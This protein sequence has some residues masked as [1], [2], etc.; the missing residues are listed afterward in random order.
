MIDLRRA[1]IALMV[2]AAAGTA[3]AQDN[4]G[5]GRP[6]RQ[7]FHQESRQEQSQQAQQSPHGQQ[8]GGEHERGPGVLSLLPADAVTQHSID[9]PNGAFPVSYEFKSVGNTVTG[10]TLGMDGMPIPL[11]NVKLEGNK[12]SFSLDLDFGQGPTTF[13]YTGVVS[14]GEIK[15]HSEFMGMPIDFSV[16]KTT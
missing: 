7:E 13:N 12:L 9:T 10:T 4:P 15:I 1:V 14:G 6:N 8:G 5:H 2:V 3:I 16:K 11:K